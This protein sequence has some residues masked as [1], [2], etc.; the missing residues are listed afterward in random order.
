M[1]LAKSGLTTPRAADALAQLSPRS[2]SRLTLL[3]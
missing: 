1:T 3:C 2:I